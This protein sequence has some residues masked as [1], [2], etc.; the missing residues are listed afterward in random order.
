M[1]GFDRQ[2]QVMFWADNFTTAEYVAYLDTDA[3]FITTVNPHDFFENT[4]A[5]IH[6]RIQQYHKID[7]QFAHWPAGTYRALH[8]EEPMTCMS[9][10][11]VI[12]KVSHLEEMRAH[13]E[14]VWHRPFDEAFL[15]IAQGIYS[16]FNI[17]CAYI[18]WHKH[19]EYTWHVRDLSPWWDGFHPPPVY[20]QFADRS[21]V[22]PGEISIR[23]ATSI[24]MRHRDHKRTKP[25]FLNEETMHILLLRGICH[26]I[27]FHTQLIPQLYPQEEENFCKL[28]LSATIPSSYF[29]EMFIFEKYDCTS[30]LN[31]TQLIALADQRKEYLRTCKVPK[32]AQ[33]EF[34]RVYGNK[35]TSQQLK[36]LLIKGN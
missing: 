15:Q 16:Q 20:A 35:Y 17:M 1:K 26:S 36:Q 14:K 29:M 32:I 6:G 34:V 33:R 11:P 27:D 2:Q 30:V 4:K 7:A 21:V 8:E 19:E 24:H 13:I 25:V 10:F 18:F 9:Y 28:H 5:I 31:E 22:A 12:L 23:P 3:L